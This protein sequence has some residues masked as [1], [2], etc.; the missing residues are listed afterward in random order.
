MKH[1][2]VTFASSKETKEKS[3][4]EVPFHPGDR[5]PIVTLVND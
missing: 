5:T 1:P 4:E 2:F 3:R